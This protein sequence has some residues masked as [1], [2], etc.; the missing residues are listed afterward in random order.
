MSKPTSSAGG[1][2]LKLAGMTA[3]IA[4]KAVSNS[5][6][7]RNSTEEEKAAARVAMYEE[8]GSQIADTL[9]HMKGAAMK[10][11]QIA[12]Q[13]Q[14]LFPPEIAKALE[15][16]Q[17]QAPAVSFSVIRAQ[18]EKELGKPLEQIFKS[19][20]EKSFAA[21]SIGQVHRAVLPDGQKVVV[22]VQYPGVAESCDSDL[23][24]LRMA[25]KLA[26]LIK[27]DRKLQ[28]ELFHEIRESLHH[29]LNYIHEAHNLNVFAAF[30][31]VKDS[32]LIIPK[33]F[34]EYTSRRVLTLSEELGDSMEQAAEYP[35]EIRREIG[36]RLFN[37]C[38]QQIFVL[39][40]FHCDP[41]PG[42]FAFRPDGTVV[43]YDFGGVKE[44]DLS[45]VQAYRQIV[46]AS[47]EENV[48]VMEDM[49][50][51]LKVR[52]HHGQIPADFYL[53]W[54][55]ILI[56][57]ISQPFDF[58][59]STTHIQVVDQLK[60]STKYWESFVPSAETMMIN[61]TVSGFYWNMVRLKVKDNFRPLTDHYI[62]G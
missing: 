4:G 47:L 28:D 24:Q 59:T 36:E 39:H 46:A 8:I 6:K 54:N 14:D 26:G 45:I 9:G 31:N 57:P 61:R 41:H 40:S 55:K 50:R 56:E 18:V 37:M 22:K 58:G 2:F 32:K 15:K 1:R 49:L 42:N 5:F 51:T 16:L 33:V 30:H 12:S 52:N 25:F 48:P 10:V 53:A 19:F 38:A 60:K 13:Y 35:D 11:G 44:L 23:K 21:A 43:V 20:D 7:S 27:I 62:K 34:T 17:R 3:S 29:E